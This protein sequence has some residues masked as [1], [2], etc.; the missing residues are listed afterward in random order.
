VTQTTDRVRVLVADESLS[1]RRQ[2][3]SILLKQTEGLIDLARTEEELFRNVFQLRPHIVILDIAQPS[4]GGLQSAH[5]IR[6]SLPETR[7]IVLSE[8]NE[9]QPIR[10]ALAAGVYCY[11]LK[12]DFQSKI[13][14]AVRAACSGLNLFDGRISEIVVHGYLEASAKGTDPAIE[15]SPVSTSLTA[16]ELEIVRLLTLGNANRQVATKLGITVRTVES[17]RA[18][19]MRKLNLHTLAQLIHFAVQ[20]GIIH[21]RSTLA[22]EPECAPVAT[23]VWQKKGNCPVPP[24]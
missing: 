19:A 5:R 20:N 16:R 22:G 24:A 14:L 23:G 9:E 15:M 1:V 21:I 2:V 7:I 13:A 3:R 4:L 8:C 18:N 11:L 12:C 6:E 10:A 17:H